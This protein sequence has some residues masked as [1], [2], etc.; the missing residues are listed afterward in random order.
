MQIQERALAIA[1]EIG[2]RDME[3]K[4]LSRMGAIC[5]RRGSAIWQ[6]S[7]TH[8]AVEYYQR[9][10]AVR[11]E[12]GNRRGEGY[13]LV[14]LGRA[15]KQLGDHQQALAQWEQALAIFQEI[16]DPYASQLQDWLEDWLVKS[17]FM[18]AAKTDD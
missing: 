11:R 1:Q 15:Y 2:D 16:Q 10:L 14:E 5:E 18:P 6:R 17:G 3:A 7:Q 9:E 13:T 4:T 12:T 8:K